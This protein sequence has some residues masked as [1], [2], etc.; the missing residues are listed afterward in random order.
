M[1]TY[2]ILLMFNCILCT[3]CCLLYARIM[4]ST[5][6]PKSE[7]RALFGRAPLV[8]LA[9]DRAEATATIGC[10]GVLYMYIYILCTYYIHI[11]YIY[12]YIYTFIYLFIYFVC[13]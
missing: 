13:I 12:I 10:E 7:F 11:I 8:P 3:I 6:T 1:Y 4:R 2:Y 5:H 9:P